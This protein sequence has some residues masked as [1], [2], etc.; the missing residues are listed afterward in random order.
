M[1]RRRRV[2]VTFPADCLCTRHI[3]MNAQDLASRLSGRCR[4]TLANRF[5]RRMVAMNSPTP[6]ISFTFDDA[7]K[8][9][10]DAG[11]RILSSYGIKATFFVSLGLLGS[12]TE[13]GTIASIDDL[14]EAVGDGNEL[15]CHTFD[16]L[17]AWETP[18]AEFIDSI[19]KN[20]Q[21]L[22]RIL[23]GTTFSSFAYPKSGARLSLKRRLEEHFTVC[24][25]GGQVPNIGMTD[26]NLAKACFLDRRTNIDTSFV[27]QLI[28]HNASARGWLILATH[29]VT[30]N[31]SPYGCTPEFFEEVVVHAVRSGALLLPVAEACQRLVASVRATA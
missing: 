28:G 9:A 27:K 18:T 16:H 1:L 15:G 20:G 3:A 11:A 30:D 12:E 31:P 19:V 10:F 5:S 7:P 2:D 29:D 8:T 22:D 6:L 21:A 26:L 17:D 14:V 4:R 25:G 23:P 13:V 24:R